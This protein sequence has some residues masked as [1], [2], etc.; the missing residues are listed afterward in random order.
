M[1]SA[2]SAHAISIEAE[3]NRVRVILGG[4]AIADT[5]KALILREGRLPAVHY[6]PREDVVAGAISR[7]G[8]RSHCPFKGDASY[9]TLTGGGVRVENGAWSYEQPFPA[10]EVI[11]GHLAFYPNRVEAIE[12]G[13]G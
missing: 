8:H 2:A 4:V 13:G 1:T 12:V 7:T 10:V 9:F 6:I 3:P 11:R 5:T